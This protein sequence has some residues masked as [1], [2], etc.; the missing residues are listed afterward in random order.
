MKGATLA[1]KGATLAMKGA[2]LAM[3]GA[4]RA[5]SAPVAREPVTRRP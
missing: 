2:T 5:P 1:M 3:K 4:L